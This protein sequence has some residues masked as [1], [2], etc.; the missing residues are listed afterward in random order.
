M[1]TNSNEEYY[2]IV[3]R[4]LP[5]DIYYFVLCRS[6]KKKFICIAES[7][8]D[9]VR[10]SFSSRLSFRITDS[11]F[12]DYDM[13]NRFCERI[14]Y[15]I[16]NSQY[17]EQICSQYKIQE[18]TIYHHY[19][20][21]L[22]DIIIDVIARGTAVV[23]LSRHLNETGTDISNSSEDLLL[24]DTIEPIMAQSS[25][26]ENYDSV[27]FNKLQNLY[28][29]LVNFHEEFE[30]SASYFGAIDLELT[31]KPVKKDN[32]KWKL[33]FPEILCC[34]ESSVSHKM[35]DG[36][37]IVGDSSVRSAIYEIQ[38]SDFKEWLAYAGYRQLY[39]EPIN[40]RHIRVLLNNIIYDVIIDSRG[41]RPYYV[42]DNT[43]STVPIT[44]TVIHF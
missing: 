4:E 1:K 33:I 44:G 14:I 13:R 18:N 41:E 20:I 36:I 35:L 7:S 27:S 42:K 5:N 43:A 12:R 38:N 30:C 3:N 10:I 29:P 9:F 16:K 25:Q 2:P 17:L 23:T 26:H 32:E 40:L 22:D 37:N 6:D 28:I 34:K 19:L 8:Q 31:I 24:E 15:E 11:S 39:G 21:S